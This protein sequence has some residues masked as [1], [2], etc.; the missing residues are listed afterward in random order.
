MTDSTAPTGYTVEYIDGPL[1]G[2]ID[3]RL[4]VDG[5]YDKTFG[6]IALVDGLESNFEYT[7]VGERELNGQTHVSYS[8]DAAS[9]DSPVSDDNAQDLGEALV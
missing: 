2:Q 9:S 7:A 3:T 1:K 4:Y 8:F 5:A 6:V